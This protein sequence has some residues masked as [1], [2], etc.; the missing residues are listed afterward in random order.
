MSDN[1]IQFPARKVV[2]IHIELDTNDNIDVMYHGNEL[3]IAILLI[4]LARLFQD[5]VRLRQCNDEV[6]E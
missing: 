3:D 6:T 1:I 2:E 4:R 5:S